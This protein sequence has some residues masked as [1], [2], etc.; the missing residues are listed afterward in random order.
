M[1][2]ALLQIGVPVG[3]KQYFQKEFGGAK[4]I[5]NLNGLSLG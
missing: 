4:V 5:G 1:F 3:S 2:F